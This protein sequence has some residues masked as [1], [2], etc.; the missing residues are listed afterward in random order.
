MTMQIPFPTS[1]APRACRRTFRVTGALMLREMSTTYGRSPGGY[2]WAVVEPAAGLALLS[3]IFS[4]GFLAPP[5]GS[6]FAIFH[7]TGMIP[8][9]VYTDISGKLGTAVMFS[10]QLL[11][12]PAV[13]YVDALIA[14]FI[15]NTLTQLMVACIIFTGILLMFETRTALELDGIVLAFSMTLALALGVGTFNCFVMSLYPVWQRIWSILN[16][17]MFILSCIF[18]TFESVPEEVRGYLWWVP[19]V[20]LTGTMRAA[21]YPG[22]EASYASP[23]YVFGLS[24]SLLATGLVFLRRHHRDVVN[25]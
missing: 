2:I 22:Y 24:L 1:P 15:L 5:M 4:L 21:F 25:I 6:N 17:P 11:A 13:S 12:Y 23:L 7:A 3:V 10:K 20:H 8:F 18:F 19:T 16:R 9:L 14:R